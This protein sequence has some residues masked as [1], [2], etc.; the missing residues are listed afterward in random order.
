MFDNI[1]FTQL[2]KFVIIGISNAAISYV[3]FYILY[4]NVLAGNAFYSQCLSYAAGIVWSF[5]WNKKLTFSAKENSWSSF[6][7]FLIFQLILLV[8]SAFL[9]V[10]AKENLDW[11]INLI[12][13]CVMAIITIINFLFTKYLVFKK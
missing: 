10:I 5:I 9:L 13:I 6:F 1:I 8:A 3:F 2:S 4:N 12:W 11:N 7:S